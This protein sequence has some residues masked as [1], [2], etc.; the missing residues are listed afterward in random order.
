MRESNLESR[1]D[2]ARADLSRVQAA[3][4]T[5][6]MMAVQAEAELA[7]SRRAFSPS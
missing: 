4:D 6:I 7:E 5:K 3:H 2:N 1:V